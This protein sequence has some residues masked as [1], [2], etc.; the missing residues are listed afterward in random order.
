MNKWKFLSIFCL[1]LLLGG[2]GYAQQQGPSIAFKTTV[3]NFGNIKEEGGVV[4]HDFTFKN[5]G[6][7]PL[8]ISRVV[9]SCGCT[10]PTWSKEPIPP[11]GDGFIRVAYNP[12]N[13]PNAFNKSI[14]VY[15]NAKQ[16]NV[17]LR[18]QGFV[19]P[20][21]K[22][23]EDEYPYQIG[24]I[25]LKTN[26]LAFTRMYKD[27]KK[28][29]QVEFINNS[30]EP[31]SVEFT[32]VPPH[33]TLEVNA[34][35]IEPGKKGTI[36]ATYDA[37][38][39]NDWGFAVD[40]AWVKIN[41]KELP[42]ARLTISASI[43]EDFSK[44]TP[45]EKANAPHISFDN[46]VFNFGEMEQRATVDHDFVF[47]NTGKSDLIIRKVSSS[48]GCTV[49]SPKEKVIKPGGSSTIKAIFNSG[50]R[51]GVQNKSITV[52][53]NDPSMPTTIL[54]LTGNV[55]APQKK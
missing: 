49:V 51:V 47:T 53:T 38:K 7:Q 5:T 21:P 8:I 9:A 26:H 42:N 24:Q 11:G 43:Q 12:R 23:L 27:Q 3:H 17:L 52:V 13:R 2:F 4:T 46:K 25:R 19:E 44:M 6:N 29:L 30:K 28:T 15:S 55:K 10:T 34:P 40:R 39:K 16:G 1:I 48:C 45:E 54:R 35:V 36:T 37:A 32:R 31:V 22:T 33:V 14:T 50:T 18:I 20:R 41:G